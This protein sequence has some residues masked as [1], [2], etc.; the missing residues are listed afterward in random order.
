MSRARRADQ[1]EALGQRA[2]VREVVDRRQQLAL[3]QVARAAEDDE[4]RRV[5][6]QPLEPLDERVLAARV[7]VAISCDCAGLRRLHGVAAELVAQRGVH[8]GRER[9]LAAADE[10]RS[11]SDVVITGVGIRLSIASSTVQRPSPESST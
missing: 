8:L 4:R 9:V 3:G 10:K 2:L 5:D 1:V 7:T 11:N 6:G